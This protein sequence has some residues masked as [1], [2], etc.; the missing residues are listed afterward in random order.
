[1]ANMAKRELN[2]MLNANPQEFSGA[3]QTAAADREE[4]AQLRQHSVAAVDP[5]MAPVFQE[6]PRTQ[7]VPTQS[8]QVEQRTEIAADEEP[9]LP[10]EHVGWTILPVGE[11]DSRG[12][13]GGDSAGNIHEKQDDEPE[14]IKRLRR[15]GRTWPGARRAIS[16]IEASDGTKYEL[17]LLP[18]VVGGLAV[19]HA[20]GDTVAPDN[21]AWGWDAT[22][23]IQDGEVVTTWREVFSD[24]KPFARAMG[25]TC[26]YHTA[27]LDERL[28]L[29]VD[30]LANDAQ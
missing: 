23:G 11:G 16:D 14:H 3:V 5:F 13:F 15:I 24:S 12:T 28:Q 20:I 22:K 19:E 21:S 17:V 26:M 25:A 7:P 1:M 2:P 9:E 10:V 27:T 30:N 6:V 18:A 29:F 8:F 4:T